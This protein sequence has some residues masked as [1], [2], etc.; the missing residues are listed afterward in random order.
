MAGCSEDLVNL[1]QEKQKELEVLDDK[2]F[3]LTREVDACNKIIWR[4][5]IHDRL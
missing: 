5:P 4:K 1:I 3:K 2:I